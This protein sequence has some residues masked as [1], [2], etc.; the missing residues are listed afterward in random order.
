MRI[1]CGNCNVNADYST[2]VS[3]NSTIVT[4]VICPNCKERIEKENENY[5]KREERDD[6]GASSKVEPE[7]LGEKKS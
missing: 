2:T 3:E 6:T 7:I 5:E 4:T 1:V